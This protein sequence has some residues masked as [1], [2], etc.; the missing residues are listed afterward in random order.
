VLFGSSVQFEDFQL[1]RANTVLLMKLLAIKGKST[2]YVHFPLNGK[3]QV[4]LN[5]ILE[6]IGSYKAKLRF[7]LRSLQLVIAK[8]AFVR[9]FKR[10]NPKSLFY[11][12]YCSNR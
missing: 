12:L 8:T 7:F 4:F 3:F 5:S 9:Q 11:M 10:I 1:L 2:I 6:V